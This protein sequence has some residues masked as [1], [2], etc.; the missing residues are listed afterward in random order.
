ML[1]FVFYVNLKGFLHVPTETNG[2]RSDTY[3]LRSVLRNQDVHS[4]YGFFS[5][6]VPDPL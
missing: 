2:H 4:G 6:R 5:F 3:L 1:L